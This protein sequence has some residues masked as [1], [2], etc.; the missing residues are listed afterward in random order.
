MYLC[1]LRERMRERNTPKMEVFISSGRDNEGEPKIE[2]AAAD[3][4][5]A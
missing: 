4:L 3:E 2:F 1:I 5:F